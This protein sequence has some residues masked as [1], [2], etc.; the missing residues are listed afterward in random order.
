MRDVK[1]WRNGDIVKYE[2]ARA[3]LI[4]EI[5]KAHA[6]HFNILYRQGG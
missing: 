4:E 1:H 2:E 5:I 6:F 3:Y